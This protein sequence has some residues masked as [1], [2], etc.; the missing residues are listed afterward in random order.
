VFEHV[1]PVKQRYRE[2]YLKAIAVAREKLAEGASLEEVAEHL[3]A[4]KLPTATGR[5]WNYGTIHRSLK[6]EDQAKPTA[7]PPPPPP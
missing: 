5:K 3:N 6:Q 2:Q 7:D 4:Q 1:L